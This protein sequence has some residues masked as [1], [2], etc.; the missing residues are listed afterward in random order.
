[1]TL[2][3]NCIPCACGLLT[4]RHQ[5]V[6][7]FMLFPQCCTHMLMQNGRYRCFIMKLLH[8][9]TGSPASLSC[10]W[11]SVVPA[12]C[13]LR[14]LC[15]RTG[16]VALGG[17]PFVTTLE[18]SRAASLTLPHAAHARG[19]GAAG[20]RRRALPGLLSL[21]RSR[22]PLHMQEDRVNWHLA[23]AYQGKHT[24]LTEGACQCMQACAVSPNRASLLSQAGA[25]ACS[26][27]TS[28]ACEAGCCRSK[29]QLHS[30]PGACKIQSDRQWRTANLV[31]QLGG[32]H[33]RHGARHA[34]QGQ[35]LRHTL[36]AGLNR[37]LF[38]AADAVRSEVAPQHP[39][40]AWTA[41]NC[42][43][44]EVRPSCS[45]LVT[46]LVCLSCTHACNS[47][48]MSFRL[49]PQGAD[50]HNGT[51]DISAQISNDCMSKMEKSRHARHT[52]MLAPL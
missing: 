27:I 9:K 49:R 30:R 13:P 24:S 45:D 31:E 7:F 26:R 39:A 48:T 51:S 8:A 29:K 3:D 18:T 20:C 37:L 32:L 21:H 2:A 23:P 38:L 1:M 33:A 34:K 6:D 16:A 35:A 28:L 17:A 15:M 42:F 47:V 4:A 52:C 50:H 36:P 12:C 5:V 43:L 10:R 41:I 22:P 11:H 14:P 46:H 19:L 40:A 25:G 44:F